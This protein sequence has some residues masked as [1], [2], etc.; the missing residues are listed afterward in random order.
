MALRNAP[1]SR[2]KRGMCHGWEVKLRTGVPETRVNVSVGVCWMGNLVNLVSK[3]GVDHKV[4]GCAMGNE[5]KSL[6]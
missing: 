2:Y 6:A 4:R 5:P 3:L 1:F